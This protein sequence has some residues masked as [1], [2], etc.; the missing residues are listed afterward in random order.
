MFSNIS[1]KKLHVCRAWLK[2][3][4]GNFSSL[5]HPLV[6]CQISCASLT[7]QEEATI[8]G[9]LW[10]L[11]G[12]SLPIWLQEDGPYGT[13]LFSLSWARIAQ[14]VCTR[15]ISTATVSTALR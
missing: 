14:F 15:N 1:R 2:P 6:T 9:P 12:T 11:E 10:H 8:R 3:R 13:F 4:F 5:T 7:A